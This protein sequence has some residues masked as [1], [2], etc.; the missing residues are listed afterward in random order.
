MY[1]F[2]LPPLARNQNPV[3]P[4]T[5]NTDESVKAVAEWPNSTSMRNAHVA[6]IGNAANQ[7]LST[8]PNCLHA[9]HILIALPTTAVETEQ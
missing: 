7:L 8:P 2:S 6:N 5:N 9:N 3:C 1:T 4:L